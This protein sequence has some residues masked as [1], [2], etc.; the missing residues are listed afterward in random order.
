[1]PRFRAPR[2]FSPASRARTRSPIC[3]PIS[4]SSAPTATPSE[5]RTGRAPRFRPRPIDPGQGGPARLNSI[6]LCA[7]G[8]SAQALDEGSPMIKDLVVAL[9]GRG[10]R[11]VAGD[12]A[13]SVAEA[14]DAHVAGIAFAYEPVIP[15]TVMGGVPSEFI[16]ASRAKSRAEAQAGGARF[17]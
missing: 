11:D 3:G 6:P 10:A 17:A 9:S 13:V 4:S 16:E 12:Y 1:G 5:N 7:G 14:F 15:G 8:S 2:W